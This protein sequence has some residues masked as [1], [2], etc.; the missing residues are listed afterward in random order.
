MI[1]RRQFLLGLCASAFAASPAFATSQFSE[2]K[3]RALK[4]ISAAESQIGVTLSYDP[5]YTKIAY[6]NGDVPMER[7][8]CTDV[9]V[10]AYRQAFGADLQKLVHEDMKNNFAVYPTKWGLKKPDTNIDHRRV[11]NLQTFFTRQKA[12]LS[13]SKD[14]VDYKPADIITMLLP[15]NLTHIALITHY[16]NSDGTKPLCIH[17]IGGGAKLEDVLFTF[18]LTGH[19]RFQ[20]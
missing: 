14:A 18:P 8:V 3:P 5:N 10:R 20:V 13:V 15:G 9:V 11:P 16:A 4:L 6:P 12:Q 1:Q 17:N 7:G 2:P 19:Y